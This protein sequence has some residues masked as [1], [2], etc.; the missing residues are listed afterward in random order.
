MN[1]FYFSF[2]LFCLFGNNLLVAIILREDV[3]MKEKSGL[4]VTTITPKN[5][6]SVSDQDSNSTTYV[7]RGFVGPHK[8]TV[9][10]AEK[11]NR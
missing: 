2:F 8:G 7:V 1:L 11:G 3:E 4:K 9:V 6:S 10:T 5:F